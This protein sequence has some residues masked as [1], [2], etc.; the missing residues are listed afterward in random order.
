MNLINKEVNNIEELWV[1][2]EWAGTDNSYGIDVIAT[3]QSA[4]SV[5]LNICGKLAKSSC[6]NVVI[7]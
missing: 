1:T 5:P 7:A 3:L 4:I 2:K 6:S